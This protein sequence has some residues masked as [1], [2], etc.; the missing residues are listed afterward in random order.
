[1]LGH[2]TILKNSIAA[3]PPFNVESI[4]SPT[5]SQI[6]LAVDNQ[7][8]TSTLNGGG[9]G[10]LIEGQAN[11]NETACIAATFVCYSVIEYNV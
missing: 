10:I 7:T 2:I 9:G 8:S 3:I 5:K 1:M 11:V 4:V 6:V